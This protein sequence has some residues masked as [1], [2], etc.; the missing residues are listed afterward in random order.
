MAIN[1]YLSIITWG[2]WMSQNR[3]MLMLPTGDYFR[4]KDTQTLKVKKWK[5]IFHANSNE[6][7]SLSNNTYIILNG[8]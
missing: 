7:K 1:T 8:P 2:I 6:K 5:K 4:S 3:S